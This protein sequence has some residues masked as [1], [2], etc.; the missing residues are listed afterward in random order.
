MNRKI[1]IDFIPKPSNQD[2]IVYDIELK[3]LIDVDVFE[4]YYKLLPVFEE[5]LKKYLKCEQDIN[6][7]SKKINEIY[8]YKKNWSEADYLF[9]L[10]NDKK[11]YNILYGPIKKIESNI[12]TLQKKVSAINQ[13][14]QIQIAKENKDI[15]EKKKNIDKIINDNIDKMFKLKDLCATLKIQKEKLS[16]SMKENE[17][18]FLLLQLIW[19]SIDKGECKCQYCGSVLKNVSKNSLFYKRSL[20]NLEKNK[21][22]MQQLLQKKEKNE[23]EL[24]KYQAEI[25]QLKTKIENDSNFKSDGFNFYKK[26]SVEVLRLEGIRDSMLNQINGLEKELNSNSDINSE[27]FLELKKRINNCEISLENIKKIKELKKQLEDE[28]NIYNNLKK[29]TLAMTGTME[30]YKKFI[31]LFFKIY[32]KKASE[33]CGKDFKFKIFDFDNYKLIE[34]FEIYYKTIKYENL[35]NSAKRHVEEMLEKNFFSWE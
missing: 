16:E 31:T 35:N 5:K 19:E 14:I 32:E 22:E 30:K 28:I 10:Q 1:L 26:K 4:E 3:D 6:E 7:Y 25:K 13:K 8:L 21:E 12:E 18:E 24:F 15:E 2:V 9:S 17:E 27:K 34:V 20:K 11:T 29:E 23:E 33:F